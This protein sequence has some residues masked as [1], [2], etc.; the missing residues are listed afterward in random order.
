M[1]LF[2]F[3]A[4]AVAVRAASENITMV[5]EDGIA[6]TYST[7]IDDTGQKMIQ[8]QWDIAQPEHFPQGW[9]DNYEIRV[10]MEVGL[11]S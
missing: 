10:C 4:L 2:V 7:Y 3:A 9:A 11:E 6:L 5:H 1:A 8:G